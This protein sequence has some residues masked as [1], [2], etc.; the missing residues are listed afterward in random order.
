MNDAIV[1]PVDRDV[2][3]AGMDSGHE[4]GVVTGKEEPALG[5]DPS[6]EAHD[7]ASDSGDGD[8]AAADANVAGDGRQIPPA[9]RSALN[10][11]RLIDPKLANRLKNVWF[12]DLAL[13]KEFPG[14]LN[15]AR[16]LREF[17][18][19]LGGDEGIQQIEQE[20]QYFQGLDQQFAMGD[21]KVLEHLANVAPEGFSKLVPAAMAK[22]A[23]TSPEHFEHIAGVMMAGHLPGG[24]MEA[25][26]QVLSS[27]E[28]TAGLA[29]H[30]QNWY[31]P[32]I[33]TLHGAP[34]R[35]V[36]PE[37]RRLEADRQQLEAGKTAEFQR[38]IVNEIERD[39]G[40]QADKI[41]DQLS[42]GKLSPEAKSRLR[43]V[44]TAELDAALRGDSGF[45]QRRDRLLAE[46]NRNKI[47]TNYKAEVGKRLPEIVKKVH[48]EFY[49]ATRPVIKAPVDIGTG[50]AAQPGRQPDSNTIDWTRTSRRDVLDGKA[51]VKGRAEQVRW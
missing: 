35:R 51:Y 17:K 13:K 44:I 4:D 2:V 11:L 22:L 16:A 10:D 46:G 37:R 45:V 49:G 7:E 42:G 15:E 43:G 12:A 32:L 27:H 1:E 21:A 30:L 24:L 8:K 40:T 14:G 47:L 50:R 28:E 6:E 39:G 36:E 31:N 41:I 25:I 23:E 34:Q 29:Q 19:R 33:Q 26:H 38:G 18:E 48:R 5:A 3:D 20:R 9:L